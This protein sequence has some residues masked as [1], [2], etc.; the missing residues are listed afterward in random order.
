MVALF[1]IE[2]IV[3]GWRDGF[4][5]PKGD[6]ITKPGQGNPV[7]SNGAL[8]FADGVPVPVSR[9]YGRAG[10]VLAD[11]GGARGDGIHAGQPRLDDGATVQRHG[12]RGA[13][14]GAIFPVVGDR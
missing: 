10:G 3:N 1:T 11:R 9:L 12:C 6:R 13:G 5:D 4:Q 7:T 8:I 2:Q 14:R